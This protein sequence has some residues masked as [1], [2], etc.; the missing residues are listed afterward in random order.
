MV[1][2][3]PSFLPACFTFFLLTSSPSLLSFLIPSS[4][5]SLFIYLLKSESHVGVNSLISVEYLGLFCTF[6]FLCN[7]SLPY[8]F[9]LHLL[10]VLRG[11]GGQVFC[12]VLFCFFGSLLPSFLPATQCINPNIP[13]MCVCLVHMPKIH[14]ASC[15]RFCSEL[16]LGELLLS[17]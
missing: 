17:K 4:S 3:F 5:L 9:S 14:D 15:K 8:D 12:F 2:L 7:I 6:M 13:K 11:R 10:Q 1:F 16:V